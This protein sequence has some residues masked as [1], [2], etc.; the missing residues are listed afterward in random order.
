MSEI[1]VRK[2]TESDLDNGF[3]ESLDSLRLASNIDK[4]KAR[5]I[6]QKISKNPDHV[7]F[8]AIQD[9]K[10]IGSTTLLIEQKFIH[11]GGKVGHIEDVVVSKQ[12]Q[13]G[14][15]GAKIIKTVLEYAK[16]QGCYKTILDCDDSV[17]EF[18][19]KLGFT[20]HS[21]EMRFDH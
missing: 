1:I 15:T 12:F 16:N 13:S 18:Y 19:E 4:N 9:G 21:N 7:I 17:K 3:L 6:L 10:V 5:Q 14:G 20:M 11:D 8:V 2:I